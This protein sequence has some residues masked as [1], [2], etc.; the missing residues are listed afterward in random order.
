MPI[1]FLGCIYYPWAKLDKMP[2]A[3]AR[4]LISPIVYMSEGLRAAAHPHFALNPTWTQAASL[5]CSGSSSSYSPEL[6]VKG[7]VRRVIG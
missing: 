6:G 1:T 3:S 5:R 7:F 4:S 2:L